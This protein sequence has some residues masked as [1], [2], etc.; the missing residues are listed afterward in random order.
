MLCEEG[1]TITVMCVNP[2]CQKHSLT[3]KEPKSNVPNLALK[4]LSSI[5]ERLHKTI[6]QEIR[7]PQRLFIESQSIR[8]CFLLVG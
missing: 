3:C 7:W 8:K 5:I 4:L 2:S 6:K 1:N